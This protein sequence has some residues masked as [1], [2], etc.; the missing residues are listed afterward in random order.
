[1]GRVRATAFVLLCLLC[2]V[3]SAAWSEIYRWTD[4]QGREHFAQNLNQVPAKYR[5]EAEDRAHGKGSKGAPSLQIYSNPG[6]STPASISAGMATAGSQAGKVWRIPV[7]RAG[8][9]MLVMVK[10]NNRVT[11]PFYIDTGASDVLVPQKVADQLG[12]DTGSGVRTKRYSTANGI[13]EQKAV[14]L[15]S[16][17]LGGATVKNVP[18]SV[19]DSMSVGLLGLSYFNHFKYKIDTANGVVTLTRNNLSDTG[20][21]RGGRSR[22]QWASEYRSMHARVERV[23]AEYERTPDS[24][25]RER[26]RLIAVQADLERQLE[27]LESEADS[28]HVPSS[29]RR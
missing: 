29:W 26:E 25:A 24:H 10:L 18:A 23:V 27:M 17:S 16:V 8:T 5:R 21:I 13:I 15:K 9:S 6:S 11:A 19:S 1:M 7:Q 12:L 14:M 20:H 4:A 3:A 22:A 2:I 28:A